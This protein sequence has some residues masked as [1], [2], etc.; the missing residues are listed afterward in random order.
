M[1]APNLAMALGGALALSAATVA[2]A[3][4]GWSE[5]MMRPLMATS[6][7]AGGAH[8]V[9]YFQP[10]NGVCRLTMMISEKDNDRVSPTRVQMI[11]EPG[12]AAYVD[13][14]EGKSSRFTCLYGAEA[15][16]VIRIERIAL[17][18]NR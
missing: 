5:A 15:M 14:T 7:D 2:S 17:A 6:L 11:V 10:T 3:E 18:H 9:S 1:K 13:D 16:N 8:L 4:P 12:R